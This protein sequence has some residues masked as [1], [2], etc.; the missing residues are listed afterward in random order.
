M[1]SHV[2]RAFQRVWSGTSSS[3][4]IALA[5]SSGFAT[6]HVL[7]WTVG[8]AYSRQIVHPEDTLLEPLSLALT[9]LVIFALFTW[10]VSEGSR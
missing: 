1:T 4:R 7:L 6:S 5:F 8:V 2:L 3:D 9:Y 10:S